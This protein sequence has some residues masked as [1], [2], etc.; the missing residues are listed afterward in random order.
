MHAT[1]LRTML[2]TGLLASPASSPAQDPVPLYPENYKVILENERVRVVDFRLEKGATEKLHSHPAHVAVFL[3]DFRIRFTLPNGETRI[4]EAHAGEVAYS[5]ATAHAS[6]NV[7][8]TDAHGILVELKGGGATA[9][10]DPSAADWITAVTLIHGI[11]GREEDLKQHLASLA[12]PTRK[13][14]G[15]VAYDLYQSPERPHEFMRY[16][17]WT[18]R[19]ALETHKRAPHLRAS[20]EKRQ[21]EG[22]TT[23][24]MV[25]KRVPE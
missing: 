2:L 16:E 14:E 8:P 19:G 15:A 18:S 11:A 3:G 4:R 10:S 13:E 21:R 7:G 23:E 12:A 6:E 5:A 25:F 24:I 9:A 20:F 17:V 22:W 1:A